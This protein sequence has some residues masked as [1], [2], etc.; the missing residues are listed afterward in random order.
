MIDSRSKQIASIRSLP[1]L[2]NLAIAG[3]SDA[4]LDT[5][6]RDGGWSP[7]QVVHHIADAHMN[8]FIRM[9]LI[10]T[11]DHPRIKPYDQDAWGKTKSYQGPIE[12]SLAIISGVQARMADFF[13][14]LSDTDWS[15]TMDH[16]ERGSESLDV[17]LEMYAQHGQSHVEQI[18]GFRNRMG[19]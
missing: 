16:P 10:L 17:V 4:Q 1:E 11:E 13:E 7:R 8:A 12:P 9:M 15:R 19:W 14:S 3:L 18:I 2:L 6:Y 5:P